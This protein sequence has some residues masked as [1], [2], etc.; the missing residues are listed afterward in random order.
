M[1][2]IASFNLSTSGQEADALS[3]FM[4]G[5]SHLWFAPPTLG[6]ALLVTSFGF[7]RQQ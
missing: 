5:C 2:V 7:D 6:R 3:K 4:T 1:S